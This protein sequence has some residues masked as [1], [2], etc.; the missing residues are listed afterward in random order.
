M[1]HLDILDGT[2]LWVSTGWIVLMEPSMGKPKQSCPSQSL[3]WPDW[4]VLW[5]WRWPHYHLTQGSRKGWKSLWWLLVYFFP[6]SML[7]LTNL[8]IHSQFC[9]HRAGNHMRWMMRCN[10]RYLSTFLQSCHTRNQRKFASNFQRICLHGAR[11]EL[12]EEVIEFVQQQGGTGWTGKEI[13]P[14]CGWGFQLIR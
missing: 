5:P 8:Q 6:Y 10:P 7:Y 13:R 1:D 14:M 2:L 11:S 12:L 9:D 4:H 3:P